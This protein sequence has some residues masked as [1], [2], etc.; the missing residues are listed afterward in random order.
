[1]DDQQL[2]AQ[3]SGIKSAVLLTAERLSDSVV[4]MDAASSQIAEAARAISKAPAPQLQ[5]QPSEDSRQAEAALEEKFVKLAEL[6]AAVYK[7]ESE[8]RDL[9]NRLKPGGSLTPVGLGDP[10]PA[11]D[12]KLIDA[13]GAISDNQ[14]ALLSRFE[15][16]EKMTSAAPSASGTPQPALDN[17]VLEKIS[18]NESAIYEKLESMER[19]LSESRSDSIMEKISQNGQAVYSKL[20]ALERNSG[21]AQL[22]SALD[23]LVKNE[24]AVYS[25]LE[26]L[27][28]NSCGAQMSAALEAINKNEQAVYSKLE[29]LERN[30]GGAQM[31]AALEAINKNE[32]AIYQKLDSVAGS[33]QGATGQKAIERIA[34]GQSGIAARL[35]ALEQ[36]VRKPSVDIAVLTALAQEEKGISDKLDALDKMVREPKAAFDASALDAAGQSQAKVTQAVGE[37]IVG[38]IAEGQAKAAQE[39]EK[40]VE[41]VEVERA[42]F[43]EGLSKLSETNA[44]LMEKIGEMQAEMEK[45]RSFSEIA[46]AP[47]PSTSVDHLTNA[48]TAMAAKL[49][50][51]DSARKATMDETLQN[52]QGVVSMERTRQ[53]VVADALAALIDSSQALQK[54]T[55][56]LRREL[57]T[58]AA[59]V[60]SK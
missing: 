15:A 21:G 27:E 42:E 28:R 8:N 47:S 26:A 56:E 35:D 39:H 54:E 12:A 9:L 48:L 4:R 57:K 19:K 58:I 55:A 36:A 6:G 1:M 50:E 59:L 10:A 17:G 11:T 52:V 23:G 37:A 34:E 51:I 46:N 20:E 13:I 43:A 14:T 40:L 49:D 45:N 32:Q 60:A 38:K 2:E 33:Q 18:R 25:K 30:S 29:A 44:R 7:L 24:Q 3:L 31:S 22:A 5:A 16:L 41:K 53:E